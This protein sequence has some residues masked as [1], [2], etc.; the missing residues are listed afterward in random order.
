VFHFD[1]ALGRF[2]LASVHP[3]QTLDDI[4]EHTG[5]A[6]DRP[7]EVPPTPAPDAATLA[8]IRGPIGAEIAET[9]PRFAASV[10][11]IG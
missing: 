1:A 2:R 3:G 6:F 7:G 11:G 4:V 10:L 9:Y 5:F 8:L